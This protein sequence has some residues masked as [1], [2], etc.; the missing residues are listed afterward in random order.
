[1]V[2]QTKAKFNANFAVLSQSY[3]QLPHVWSKF[4]ETKG[5]HFSNLHSGRRK[6]IRFISAEI[7]AHGK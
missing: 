3:L 5:M 7:V 4:L 2:E 6:K 1:M